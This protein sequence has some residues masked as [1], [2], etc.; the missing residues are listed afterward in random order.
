MSR[1]GKKPVPIP[2]GVEVSLQGQKIRVKGPKGEL[3]REVH[4]F[5]KVERRESE[6]VV[7]RESDEHAHR[8]LHGLTRALV[9][10][11]VQGVSQGFTRGLEI[12]GVGYR[13][14]LEGRTITLQLGYSHPVV[15][16]LPDGVQVEVRDQVRMVVSGCDKQ[17]VG[18]VAADIRSLRPP[19]PY[20]AKGV[21]YQGERVRRKQG[22]A[23]RA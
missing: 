6:L 12:N 18:Q 11:M 21:M 22:K 9:A 7:V 17:Q 14:A 4:P 19:D 13:A 2:Q 16:P 10:N 1:I 5:I 8:A 23:G 3:A 20:K 15:F